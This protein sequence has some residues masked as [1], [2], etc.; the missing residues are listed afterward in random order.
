MDEKTYQ[1]WW[2]LHVRVARNERLSRLEQMEYDRGL[3]VLDHAERQEL[4]SGDASA[5]RQLRAQIEQLQTENA[6]LQARSARLD[7][8]I[9]TLERAYTKQVGYELAGGAYA[10]S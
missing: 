5:L 4:A 8:Q 10:V 2:Q 6:Q 9:R 1:Q 3:Q 7:R